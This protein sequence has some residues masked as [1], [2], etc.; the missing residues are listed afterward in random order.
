MQ[1]KLYRMLQVD[2]WSLG[3]VLY[4]MLA[5]RFPEFET[6]PGGKQTVRMVGE[7]WAP[8]SEPA[9]ALIRGLMAHDPSQ[10]MSVDQALRHPWLMQ[11]R[12]PLPGVP[13]AVPTAVST[14]GQRKSGEDAVARAARA[15]WGP[16]VQEI[17]TPPASH[18]RVR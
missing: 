15:A 2:C 9:K 14:A 18:V 4:V 8:V 12:A 1:Y 7:L 13:T 17:E 6:R 11:S 5:A 3:A 16:T 10:R